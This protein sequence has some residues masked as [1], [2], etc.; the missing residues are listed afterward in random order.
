LSGTFGRK[1]FYSIL[2]KTF[3]GV[4]YKCSK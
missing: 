3:Y 2:I 4:I 1:K